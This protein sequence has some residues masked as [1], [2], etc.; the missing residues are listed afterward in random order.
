MRFRDRAAVRDETL[1]Q[2]ERVAAKQPGEGLRRAKGDKSDGNRHTATQTP[3]SD[4]TPSPRVRDVSRRPPLAR[5]PGSPPR[6][7]EVPS[8]SADRWPCRRLRLCVG[9][10]DHRSRW[11][12]PRRADRERFDATHEDRGRGLFRSPLHERR[13]A[14]S[15]SLGDRRDSARL[16][17]SKRTDYAATNFPHGLTPATA[18]SPHPSPSATPSPSGRGGLQGLAYV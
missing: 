17:R 2:R 9:T 16:R 12:T 5:A 4:R 1:S 3:N 18:A 10:A 8:S 14:W 6:R 13:C 7:L 15:P 11:E